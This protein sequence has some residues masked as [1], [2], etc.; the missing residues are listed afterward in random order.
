MNVA[1]HG[2]LLSWGIMFVGSSTWWP[3]SVP[4]SCLLLSNIPAYGYCVWLT[5]PWVSG[6]LH[7]FH[8]LAVVNSAAVNI[9]VQG[10]ESPSSG[11]GVDP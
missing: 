5:H 9:H 2:W 7:C 3:V 6:Y 8:F 1:L 10:L 11:P 4:Q